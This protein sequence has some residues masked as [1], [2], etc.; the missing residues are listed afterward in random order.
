MTKYSFIIPVYNVKR[1]LYR[2]VNSVLKQDY[3]DYEIILVDDGSSDGSQDLCD[4][5]KNNDA[6]IKV[7]HKHN[8]GL[9]D[10]RNV[11]LQNAIG[12]YVIFLDSDDYILNNICLELDSYTSELVDVVV[13]DASVNVGGKL[14]HEPSLKG[15]VLEG[16]YFLKESM[17][18]KKMPMAAWLYIYNRSFLEKKKLMFKKGVLHEDEEFTPR[19]I[20]A[21]RSVVYSGI[22]YYAYEIHPMS[23]TTKMDKSQNLIDLYGTCLELEKIYEKL[24][25]IVLRNLLRDS[26]AQKFLSLYNS[27]SLY[28]RTFSFSANMFLLRN[29]KFLKTKVKSFLFILSPR[30]YCLLNQV[31]KKTLRC[32]C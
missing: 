15:L 10:A 29:S 4:Q 14:V 11:G 30:F 6:R 9:S 16:K 26:L 17:K 8:G 24:D 1:Y 28:E 13:A 12:E 19:A 5:I 3:K 25:D 22:I 32:V 23:I 27:G 7:I 31:V 21:A 18:A 20:L 2:C